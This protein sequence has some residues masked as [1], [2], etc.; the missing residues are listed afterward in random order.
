MLVGVKDKDMFRMGLLET[1][2]KY[3]LSLIY[4]IW[5]VPY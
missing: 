4:D 1:K 2:I 5:G 3:G